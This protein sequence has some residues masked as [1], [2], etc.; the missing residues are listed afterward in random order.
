MRTSA[1]FGA[2]NFEYFQVYGVW[3]VRTD[4]KEREVE[5]ELVGGG[6]ILCRR[7]LWAASNN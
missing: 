3:C 7:L 4:K 2:K 6:A 1:L 5:L